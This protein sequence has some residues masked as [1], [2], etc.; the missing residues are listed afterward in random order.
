MLTYKL[1][2]TSSAQQHQKFSISVELNDHPFTI[3]WK[4]YFKRT[5]IRCPHLTWYSY[6]LN[7]AKQKYTIDECIPFLDKIKVALEF[8]SV[9]SDDD[10]VKELAQINLVLSNPLSI[11]QQDLNLWHRTFTRLAVKYFPPY[12][13][14]P[15]GIDASIVTK[16]I[17]DIN[18][19]VHHLEGYTYNRLPRRTTL[20]EQPCIQ[21]TA[22]CMDGANLKYLTN[23]V[24]KTGF[25]ETIE[26]GG[27]DFNSSDY[28]FNVWLHEDIQ[29]K[30]QF[31][32]WLDYDDL[33]QDDITGN[34]LMTPNITFDPNMT[35]SRL[36]DT[37]DFRIESKLSNKTIDRYPL[38]NIVELDKINWIRMY[39]AVI[40]EI[41]LDNQILYQL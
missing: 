25:Y 14:M 35:Y 6:P 31:K 36:I 41:T 39:S 16:F 2:D 7:D 8:F 20:F 33:T 29:G 5:L 11:T 28:N 15:K 37:E 18:T 1:Y 23:G 34:M 24:W 27:F 13:Q 17:H 12:A 30:D 38:G 9:N 19:N 3:R 26:P 4:D 21:Y 32:A 10:V 22:Q 40:Q